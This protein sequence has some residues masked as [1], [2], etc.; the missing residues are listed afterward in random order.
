MTRPDRG[1]PE[2]VHAAAYAL[3]RELL[4]IDTTNPPGNERPAAEC[5]ADFLAGVGLDVELLE[6][7]PGRG[8]VVARLT[9]DGTKPPLALVGHLDVVSAGDGTWT[10]PPFAAE[11][12]E[13]WLWGRGAVDMKNMVAMSAAIV[14]RLAEEGARLERDLIL[15]ACADEEAGCDQG[16]AWL[17]DHHPEKVVCEYALGEVGGF[18]LPV[19][20][21]RFYPIQIAE[22][23]IAWLKA[24]AHGEAGHGS[25]PREDSAVL[26]LAEAIAAIGRTRLP[27]H[28]VEASERYFRGVA[29]HLPVPGRWIFPRVL[30]PVWSGLI[31]D[32]LIADP[33]LR[34]AIKAALSNTAS[35]TV[36]SG[37]E[38]INVIPA[39]ASVEIDGRTLPGQTASDLVAEL[40]AICG[41]HVDFEILKERPPVQSP[42][43]TEVFRTLC[44]AIRR[45]DPEGI[46]V[47][48]LLPGFT[49]AKAM[50]QVGAVWYGFA[51]VRLPDEAGVKFSDLYHRPNERIPIE[52]FHWGLDVL[53]DAVRRIAGVAAG[54]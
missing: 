28:R 44:E 15:I 47:P 42:P 3:L 46:P 26:R 18:S 6:S 37:G 30:D 24:T 40:K 13:G 14:R 34:R 35:P 39:T 8:N 2:E 36:L 21:R 41:E 32:R 38:K 54:G 16:S 49:D 50:H 5:V 51:P 45:G 17:V 20:G 1:L 10:H 12:A 33:A 11:E 4:R 25:I 27:Q 43:D 19:M 7:A 9:G 53:D 29:R 52:G 31:L 48:Y 23:G 22:K